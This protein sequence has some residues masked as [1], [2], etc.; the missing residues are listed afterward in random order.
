MNF[1][2]YSNFKMIPSLQKFLVIV[3]V[4]LQFAAPLVHAHAHAGDEIVDSGLHVPGLESL[5][6]GSSESET[7]SIDRHVGYNHCI[8]S[9][10]S[11]IQLKYQASNDQ[12]SD[13]VLNQP[14]FS[15]RLALLDYFINFSPQ[16]DQPLSS[17][18]ISQHS[19]R[20]PPYL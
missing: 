16:P 10:S 17:P 14:G 9:I 6:I 18:F 20:A 8:V 5:S 19:T 7:A 2:P 4:L 3:L 12:S 1:A 15:F 11:G 13:A